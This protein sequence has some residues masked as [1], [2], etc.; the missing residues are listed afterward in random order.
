[1]RDAR[2]A[3]DCKAVIVLPVD[4]GCCL[5]VAS[6]IEKLVTVDIENI[7]VIPVCSRCGLVVLNQQVPTGLSSPFV[8]EQM[9][10][11]IAR[12]RDTVFV[13]DARHHP[14]L[15]K[16]AV[17]KLNTREAADFLGNSAEDFSVEQAKEIGKKI[18][19]Q[20]GKAV[21]LT[22]GER[23]ILVADEGRVCEIPGILV[24]G[25]TRWE[26]ATWWWQQ[27]PQGFQAGRSLRL[28]LAWRTWRLL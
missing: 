27:L 16:G 11:V 6:G 18:S 1:M 5:E 22:R 23:G 24:H 9:N 8:V 12:H 13:V 7:P 17:L 3:T 28:R 20:T 15:Y 10:E 25:R 14:N 21:F 19:R 4:R 26:R 2:R